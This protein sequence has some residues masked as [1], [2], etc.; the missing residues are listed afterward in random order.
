MDINLI[1]QQNEQSIFKKFLLLA[2]F[3]APVAYISLIL[4]VAIHEII[5]HGLAAIALGGK[6]YGFELEL[7]GM[8][9]ASCNLPSGASTTDN[10]IHLAAGVTATTVTGLVL[11]AVAYR[12]R[13]RLG[14]RLSLL[15]LSFMC[16]MEGI[17][18]VFWN[19]YNPV[20]PGDIGRIIAL[21]LSA[22]FSGEMGI[23]IFLLAASG[24][25][26][27]ISIFFLCALL[28]QGIEEAIL[29]GKRFSPQARF[30]VLLLF[31]VIPGVAAWFL[32]DWN[33]IAPG[34]GLLPCIV[35]AASI[36]ISAIILYWFSLKPRSDVLGINIKWYHLLI[37]YGFLILLVAFIYV[38]RMRRYA[39]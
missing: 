24:I 19:S 1:V 6:F 23:R 3:L 30:W 37:S 18:Y 20:P 35:G 34:V 31:L 36:V 2:L 38:S 4:S 12:I 32:F 21:W 33:Q 25:M 16:L 5:G 17:P 8:G 14:I 28:L 22:G 7:D 9:W 29:A 26:F 11:L 27:C 13:K 39:D 10:I 15:I